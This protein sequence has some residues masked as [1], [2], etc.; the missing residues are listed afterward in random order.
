[1]LNPHEKCVMT[2]ISRL[3]IADMLN[4]CIDVTKAPVRKFTDGDA[5]LTTL[6]C[7]KVAD[8]LADAADDD[9]DEEERVDY[10]RAELY[11]LITNRFTEG[12]R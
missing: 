4:D 2:S 8:I 12:T 11:N 10:R 7:G 3:A 1:M 6:V 9:L 5:R